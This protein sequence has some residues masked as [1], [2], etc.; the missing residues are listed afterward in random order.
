M[1]DGDQPLF[2]S[3]DSS[4]ATYGPQVINRESFYYISNFC[5]LMA[6]TKPNKQSQSQKRSTVL[7]ITLSR[8]VR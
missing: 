2:S 4:D 7:R 6:V 5:S 8:T 3:H 1:P